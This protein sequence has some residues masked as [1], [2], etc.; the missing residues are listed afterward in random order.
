[1]T[2]S[3]KLYRRHTKTRIR[4]NIYRKKHKK[5]QRGGV[6]EENYTSGMPLPEGWRL[7]VYRDNSN[8]KEL[9]IYIDPEHFLH[10]DHPNLLANDLQVRLIL[11]SRCTL[12]RQEHHSIDQLNLHDLAYLENLH[13]KLTKING[14]CVVYLEAINKRIKELTPPKKLSDYQTYS[15]STEDKIWTKKSNYTN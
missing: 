5:T 1:M 11:N 7:Y 6:L 9:P 3:I 4:R 15:A 14:T 10:F 2:R 12:I 13:N 8:N